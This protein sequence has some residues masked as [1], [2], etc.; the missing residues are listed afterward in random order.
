MGVT[1][2]I[3][4]DDHSSATHRGLRQN[5]IERDLFTKIAP[6][7]LEGS[8][9]RVVARAGSTSYS[10]SKDFNKRSQFSGRD[11]QMETDEE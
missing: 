8:A 5:K 1:K 10:M 7:H 11:P 4:R 2:V 9:V 6:L 3:G